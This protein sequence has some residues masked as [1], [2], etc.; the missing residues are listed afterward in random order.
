MTSLTYRIVQF[1]PDPFSGARVPLAALVSDGKEVRVVRASLIPDADCLGGP[2]RAA[3][4]RMIV[5]ALRGATEVDQLPAAVGPQAVLD[6]ARRVP[7]PDLDAAEAWVRD[8]ILPHRATEQRGDPVGSRSPQR[9]TYGKRFF[10]TWKVAEYV[11]A[12]FRPASD[13]GGRFERLASYGQA[14]H[15]VEG[16]RSVLLMEP[17]APSRHQ[18][19]D[20]LREVAKLFGSYRFALDQRPGDAA[21]RLVAYVLR[22]ATDEQKADA[23]ARLDAAHEIVDTEDPVERRR[24]I[25]QIRDL[26][27]E[28]ASG[29]LEAVH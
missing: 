11:H 2:R 26:G 27:R 24:F 22:G 20:D 23:A 29:Q 9:A 14:S 21:A 25:E 8:H 6:K 16:S 19:G 12:T 1:I 7:V 10:E 3:L 18:L 17:I 4:A 15:W 28:R 5:S 13:F